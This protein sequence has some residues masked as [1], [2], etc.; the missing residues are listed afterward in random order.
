MTEVREEER[1]V[2]TEEIAEATRRVRFDEGGFEED[3]I[4]PAETAYND[5]D[6]YEFTSISPISPDEQD[7]S[8]LEEV[9]EALEPLASASNSTASSRLYKSTSLGYAVPPAKN[10]KQR[11]TSWIKQPGQ[12]IKLLRK[13]SSSNYA[14]N[15]K[16]DNVEVQIQ[17]D[18]PSWR[19]SSSPPTSAG[20]C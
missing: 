8:A 13:V 10:S 20:T 17:T 9:D 11:L 2:S 18:P 1:K 16:P 6:D 4:I 19:L 15:S 3:E 5:E 7:A 12:T 14:H